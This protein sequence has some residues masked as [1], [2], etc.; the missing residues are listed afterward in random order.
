MLNTNA[1]HTP[2]AAPSSDHQL[3]PP[4]VEV[5]GITV[6]RGPTTLV[7]NVSLSVRRGEIVT[8]VGPNGSGKSTTVKSI[9]GILK[10]QRG[11]IRVA[12]K[13]QIGYVP[14]Q[15]EINWSMPL[16]VRR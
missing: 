16:N 3:Q 15:L 11:T 8:I 12:P 7:D 5:S 10:P 14:Q 6:R 2:P 13:T 9:L 4:L 1:H